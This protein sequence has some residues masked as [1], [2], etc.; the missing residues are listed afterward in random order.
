VPTFVEPFQR[1]QEGVLAD[2][3]GVGRLGDYR[4]RHQM[5]GPQVTADQLLEGR[6]VPAPGTLD[7]ERIWFVHRLLYL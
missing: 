5:R 6:A 2:V 4:E 3:I 7:Q 1:D